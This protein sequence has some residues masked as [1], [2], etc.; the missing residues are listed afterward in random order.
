MIKEG[1]YIDAVRID[2]NYYQ[3]PDGRII[4]RKTRDALEQHAYESHTLPALAAD[5]KQDA[6]KRAY[7]GMAKMVCVGY[8][9]GRARA[10][11]KKACDTMFAEIDQVFAVRPRPP[12][13]DMRP[14]DRATLSP[15]TP[16]GKPC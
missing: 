12:I 3:L 14:H 5:A 2:N 7:N 15:I 13:H 10:M 1:G 8:G 6:E 16:V 4:D 11:Y 9:W